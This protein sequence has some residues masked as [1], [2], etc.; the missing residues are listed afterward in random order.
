MVAELR[1]Q[2]LTQES[3]LEIPEDLP[4]K[5]LLQVQQE[6]AMQA[7]KGSL[8]MYKDKSSRSFLEASEDIMLEQLAPRLIFQPLVPLPLMEEEEVLRC[9]KPR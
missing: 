2:P 6:L 5:Q 4:A 1:P 3:L 7:V 8:S 9:T